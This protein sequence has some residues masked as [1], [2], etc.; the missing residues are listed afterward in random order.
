MTA[1]LDLRHRSRPPIQPDPSAR[2]SAAIRG[3]LSCEACCDQLGGCVPAQELVKRRYVAGGRAHRLDHGRPGLFR[4]LISESLAQPTGPP[5][6]LSLHGPEGSRAVTAWDDLRER[7]SILRGHLLRPGGEASSPAG[8][9]H[10]VLVPSS[11]EISTTT[12]TARAAEAGTA[13]C[14]W[15]VVGR[16][17][18]RPRHLLRRDCST[19]LGPGRRFPDRPKGGRSRR[20]L[21]W[22]AN[23]RG[24]SFTTQTPPP[25]FPRLSVVSR[26]RPRPDSGRGRCHPG[27][28]G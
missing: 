3:T 8:P 27:G 6:S 11:D 4:S 22:C 25:N 24:Q 5:L 13:C 17:G 16:S 26:K 20:A 9:A 28:G 12:A 14:V 7:G 19:W 2:P 21:M 10:L 15:R 1:L 23:L 18:L